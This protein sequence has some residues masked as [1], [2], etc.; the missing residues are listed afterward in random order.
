M[1]VT[2]AS[3]CKDH[4]LVF[5]KIIASGGYGVVYLVFSEQYKQDFALKRVCISQ[6]KKN[7]VNMM[8]KLE[9]PHICN[10]YQYWFYDSY[11]YMLLEYCPLSLNQALTAFADPPEAW[12]VHTMRQILLGISACHNM[13][14]SHSD[15]K[16]ANILFDRY[17]RIKICDFGLACQS[18]KHESKQKEGSLCF[19]APEIFLGSK[20]DPLK[21][22]VWSLGVTFYYIATKRLPFI[23]T[24]TKEYLI[25][26]IIKGFYDDTIIDN[27]SLR[28]LIARC[29]CLDPNKRPTVSQLLEHPFLNREKEQRTPLNASKCLTTSAAIFASRSN[30]FSIKQVKRNKG[31][32]SSL[33]FKNS[34]MLFQ[35]KSMRSSMY[36]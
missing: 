35:P 20:Y 8:M 2:D 30:Y 9:S 24:T 18:D 33:V 5:K 11:V 21:A 28:N 29:L 17:G 22:D 10:L 16:P 26:Q 13:N 27:S 7:E 23:S 32:P 12:T 1:E 36:F 3:F 6:F 31:R 4:G 34:P 14:I 19:M 15:I 25:A